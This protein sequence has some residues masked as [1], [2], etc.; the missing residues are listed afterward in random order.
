MKRCK[1]VHVGLGCCLFAG[2]LAAQTAERVDFGKDV[3]PIFRQNC[4]PCHGPAQQ[5]NGLRL[6]GKARL[7]RNAA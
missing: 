6:I 3:Q 7:S 2:E 4:V 1:V 5:I